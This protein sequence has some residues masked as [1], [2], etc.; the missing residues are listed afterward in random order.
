MTTSANDTAVTCSRRGFHG[1]MPRLPLSAGHD[2]ERLG[3]RI[4]QQ[5]C[6]TYVAEIVPYPRAGT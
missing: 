3:L 4:S 6:S 2:Y 5:Y 1:K